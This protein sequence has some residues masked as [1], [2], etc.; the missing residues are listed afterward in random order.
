ML[1]RLTPTARDPSI[2]ASSRRPAEEPSSTVLS[3]S[4]D[5]RSS[6]AP[7]TGR[8]STDDRGWTLLHVGARKGNV[9]EVYRLLDEDIDARI[10][11]ACGSKVRNKEANQ[12]Q[13]VKSSGQMANQPV[14]FIRQH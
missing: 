12:W 3:T 14:G 13:I 1:H 8:R 10:K 2:A 6:E 9:K 5:R 4:T 11:G 7:D